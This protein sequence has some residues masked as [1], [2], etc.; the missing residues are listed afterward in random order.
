MVTSSADKGRIL[1]WD[2]FVRAAHWLLVVAFFVAYFTEEELLAA[3]VWAGY[4][5]GTVVLAR[6][7]WGFFGTSHARFSDF[8][9]R[10]STMLSYFGNLLRGRGRRYLGHSPA[11]GAM[12]ILLLLGLAAITWSGL[13]VY[14]YDQQAGPLARFVAPPAVSVPE[15][16]LD[17][18]REEQEGE[19]D[20]FEAREGYWE[21]V[22]ELFVNLTLLFVIVHVGGVLLASFVH[23]ENLVGAMLTGRKRPLE[24]D[25]QANV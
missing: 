20:A 25:P 14:A 12:V 19:A 23:K 9:Y 7:A 16:A 24:E 1:V 5:V 15:A 21:E 3:H 8:L 4:A 13:M 11:G 2:P 18:D 6:V 10:P 17:E 22:H